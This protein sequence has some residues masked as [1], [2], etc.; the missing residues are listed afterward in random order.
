MTSPH[1][2]GDPWEQTD[3]N[4]YAGL[5]HEPVDE[6]TQTA[7]INGNWFWSTLKTVTHQ[8]IPPAKLQIGRHRKPTQRRLKWWKR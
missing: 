2:P 1:A 3:P 4:I 5:G 8:P 7:V 6:F